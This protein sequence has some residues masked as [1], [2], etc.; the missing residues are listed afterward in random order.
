MTDARHALA[1]LLFS[2]GA[3]GAQAA[4]D[5]D[6]PSAQG[7]DPVPTGWE[8]RLDRPTADRSTLRFVTMG[9]GMHVTGGPAAIFWNAANSATG[10]YT[11]EVTFTQ[12]KAPTHAEAYGIA[13]GG[14]NLDGPEQDYLYFVIRKDGKF[15]VKHRAG[16]ATHDI[17]PW[18]EHPAIVKEGADGKA[19]N[20]LRVEVTAT[21]SRLYAN[22]QL[23]HEVPKL[24]MGA[25]TDGIVALRVNHNLDVHI[26]GFTIRR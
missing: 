18:T 16:A 9:P 23:V 12:M 22:G 8:I 26:A 3:L 4:N 13:W 19:T 25:N 5:P 15:L 24:G 1:A 7:A 2:A 14:R 10:A 21:N 17:Q 20:T 6:K 11:A